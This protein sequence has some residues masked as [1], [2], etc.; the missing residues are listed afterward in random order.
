MSHVLK[1]LENRWKQW[2]SVDNMQN[3]WL[4]PVSKS[5]F[6]C[7]WTLQSTQCWHLPLVW[8]HA[9]SCKSDASFQ[10]PPEAQRCWSLFF[11]TSP[12]KRATHLDS[13]THVSGEFAESYNTTELY[14]RLVLQSHSNGRQLSR[15]N[16]QL[17]KTKAELWRRAAVLCQVGFLGCCSRLKWAESVTGPHWRQVMSKC[18]HR[19]EAAEWVLYERHVGEDWRRPRTPALPLCAASRSGQSN[20][21]SAF[22]LH[23]STLHCSSENTVEPLF[24]PSLCASHPANAA[25]D[26]LNAETLLLPPPSPLN[27][28]LNRFVTLFMCQPLKRQECACPHF[29]MSQ[30]LYA[31]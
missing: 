1:Y 3:E 2:E 27:G 5:P 12:V 18:G 22:A 9:L 10:Q 25:A 20:P 24:P 21:V 17:A 11:C 29:I 16:L 19:E 14:N 31:L 26:A 13:I 15:A 7:C 8:A 4:H 30:Q 6:N 28:S 23:S